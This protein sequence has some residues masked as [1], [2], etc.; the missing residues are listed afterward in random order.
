MAKNQDFKKLQ[1][2]WYKKLKKD[3]FEDI[4]DVEKDQLKNWSQNMFSKSMTQAGGWQAKAEYYSLASR[5]LSEYKFSRS[6]DKVIWEY[7]AEGI[8]NRD[9]ATT[10][11]KARVKKIGRGTV[12]N[13]LKALKNKMYEMYLA[14]KKEYHE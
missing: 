2:K 14:P 12:G 13:I 6:I 10:L 8:S 1:D 3:G 9:I 5:F 11:K 4:E 7:H